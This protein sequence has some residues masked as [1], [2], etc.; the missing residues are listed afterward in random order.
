MD[1]ATLGLL[2][3]SLCVRD[4]R[5]YAQAL[6]GEIFHYH[7]ETGREAD[8]A[9]QLRDGRYA[10]FKIKLGASFVDEGAEIS[11]A[12]K[13]RSTQPLWETQHSAQ[14]SHREAVP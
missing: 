6:S 2:F 8:A 4:L 5:V 9:I 10:L 13:K 7:D 12:Y 1:T 3:E 14:S 11:C